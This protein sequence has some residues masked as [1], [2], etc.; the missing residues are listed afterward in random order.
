[1]K[2]CWRSVGSLSAREVGATIQSLEGNVAELQNELER[3]RVEYH[4][5]VGSGRRCDAGPGGEHA[6]DPRAGG[7]AGAAGGGG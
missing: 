7:A 6:A 3:T 1:M 4:V 2:K 5:S